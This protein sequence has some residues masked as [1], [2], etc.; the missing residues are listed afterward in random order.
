VLIADDEQSILQTTTM[1]LT[2]LGHDVTGIAEG[3]QAIDL[4]RVSK[5]AGSPFDVVILAL[6][7]P[8]GPDG[9]EILRQLLAIDP[10]V[11]AILSS[12]DPNDPQII[13]HRDYGFKAVLVKPYRIED[14]N[15]ALKLAKG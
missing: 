8:T 13:N 3:K 9:V 11:S 15:L 2:H 10:G 12:G 5:E 4:Y 1:L 7:S 14:L 6:I